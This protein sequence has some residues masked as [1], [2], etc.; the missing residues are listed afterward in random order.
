MIL[1]YTEFNN[2]KG[3]IDL[4]QFNLIDSTFRYLYSIDGPNNDAKEFGK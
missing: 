3:R 2:Y 4:V 1:A